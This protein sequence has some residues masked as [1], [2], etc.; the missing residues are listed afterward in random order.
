MTFFFPKKYLKRARSSWFFP[1][2]VCWCWSLL[3]GCVTTAEC[4]YTSPQMIRNIQPLAY[5][6]EPH[7]ALQ[8]L[9]P[10]ENI[11]LKIIHSCVQ[12]P[13]A[14]E[15]EISEWICFARVSGL[16]VNVPVPLYPISFEGL[17]TSWTPSACAG[18]VGLLTV[19]CLQSWSSA[20]L[21]VGGQEKQKNLSV[22]RIFNTCWC[23]S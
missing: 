10:W 23:S 12:L 21:H 2:Y 6:N 14:A 8:S 1:Y 4:F 16:S 11:C 18:S 22:D 3:A 15:T 20:E 9:H 19:L 13:R 17:V 7:L 5:R